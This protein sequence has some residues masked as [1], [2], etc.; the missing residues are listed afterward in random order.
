M[1]ES[2]MFGAILVV[3]SAPTSPSDEWEKTSHDFQ[4]WL[5]LV[6]KDVTVS[7]TAVTDD[8]TYGV[9]AAF[10]ELHARV[11]YGEFDQVVFYGVRTPILPAIKDVENYVTGGEPFKGPWFMAFIEGA[12]L[13][14]LIPVMDLTPLTNGLS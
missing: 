13:D 3:V 6:A 9:R 11:M 1:E 12:T 10:L 14:S 5:K 8:Q 2:G 4:L 7:R